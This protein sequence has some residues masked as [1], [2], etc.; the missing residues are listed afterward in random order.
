MGCTALITLI[1]SLKSHSAMLR[2][3][4]RSVH[5]AS[6]AIMPQFTFVSESTYRRFNTHVI[7]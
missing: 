1:P 5:F 3:I 4:H 6:F 7:I 2:S